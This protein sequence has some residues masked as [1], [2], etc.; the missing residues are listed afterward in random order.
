[1]LHGLCAMCR[2]Q[3]RLD[4]PGAAWAAL[5]VPRS[6]SMANSSSLPQNKPIKQAFLA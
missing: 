1:M 4:G 6:L 3:S 2:L 5:E